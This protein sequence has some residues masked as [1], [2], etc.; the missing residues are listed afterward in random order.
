MTILSLSGNL[1]I[2]CCGHFLEVKRMLMIQWCTVTDMASQDSQA[3]KIAAPYNVEIRKKREMV[4]RGGTKT[5]ARMEKIEKKES[6]AVTHSKRHQ[7]LFSKAS[8]LCL[9]SGAQIAVLATPPSSESNASFYS[10]GHSSVDAVV[11]AF[12]SG[13]RPPPVGEEPREDAG[14]CLARKH[15]GLGMWWEDEALARSENP[16]ELTEAINSISFLMTKFKELRKGEAFC[17]PKNHQRDLKRGEDEKIP[18]QTLIRQSDYPISRMVPDDI[19]AV[20]DDSPSI[21]EEQSEILALCD[22]FCVTEEEEN[23]NINMDDSVLTGGSFDQ[24][25]DFDFDTAFDSSAFNEWPLESNPIL[26]DD[27]ST[28]ANLIS[29]F[30]ASDVDEAFDTSA[31]QNWL[32][33]KETKGALDQDNRRFSDSF[34]TIAAV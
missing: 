34:N 30:Q 29:D 1:I 24:E 10:F 18:D 31:F 23:N 17:Q 14:I 16:Q 5:K 32:F 22:S 33:E 4:K 19:V 25:M 26:D 11:S 2:K 20:H 3:K 28:D 8:Q 7:G 15:L 27:V 6:K 12:L 13:N 21:T 9:L